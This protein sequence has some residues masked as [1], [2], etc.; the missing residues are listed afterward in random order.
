MCI[1][2]EPLHLRP[3]LAAAQWFS[4][5]GEEYLTGNDFFFF[6]IFQQFAAQ[7]GGQEDRADVHL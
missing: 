2:A 7:L 4:V 6:G 3:D 1:F 5:S